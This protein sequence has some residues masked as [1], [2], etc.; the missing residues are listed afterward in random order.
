M[1]KNVSVVPETGNDKDELDVNG[2]FNRSTVAN[3]STVRV[4]TGL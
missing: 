4:V 1:N 3:G 2:T